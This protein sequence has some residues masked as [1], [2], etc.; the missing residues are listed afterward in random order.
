MTTCHRAGYEA[1]GRAMLESFDRHWPDSVS[2]LLYAEEFTPE[3][4]GPRVHV[5]D[6]HV[7]CPELLAFK[8]RHAD[9][10]RAHGSGDRPRWALR[11]EWSPFKLKLRRK[12]SIGYRWDAVRFSHKVFAL[13]HAARLLPADVLILLDAD[14]LFVAD[15]P[16]A[17]LEGLVPR[18]GFVG[19]LARPKFSECGFVAY[20]LRHPATA[21]FI[22]EFEGLYTSDRLFRHLQ[23]HDSYLFDVV[24]GRFERRGCR[25]YDVAEGAGRRNGQV[26]AASR[27]APYMQHRKGPGK[28]SPRSLA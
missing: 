16:A 9:D 19:Y 18:D 6:L 22:E 27:L 10:P 11:L 24:R 1:Y 7:S 17:L 15:L 5:R 8:Q 26:L 20:N 25:S 14:L 4:V 12:R 28:C 23:W 21:S 13:S 3:A 2:L